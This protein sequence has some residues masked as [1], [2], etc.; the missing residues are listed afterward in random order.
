MNTPLWIGVGPG[1]CGTQSL[2]ASFPNTTHEQHRFDWLPTLGS[3]R[4]AGDIVAGLNLTK[5]IGLVGW[6]YLSHLQLIRQWVQDTF[7]QHVPVVCMRRPRPQVVA[8]HD[9]MCC[10]MDRISKVGRKCLG[11]ARLNKAYPSWV[12]VEKGPPAWGT[13]WD[14]TDAMMSQL[15][16][17]KMDFWLDELNDRQR[18]LDLQEFLTRNGVALPAGFE[19]ES[20]R[21][22]VHGMP[23]EPVQ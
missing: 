14:V 17:P 16:P 19:A 9:R 23:V 7:D 15:A 3:V 21:V 1:R 13:W 5:S 18:M 4:M 2:A 11:P 8:S 6:T 22:D 10:G 20:H 12:D